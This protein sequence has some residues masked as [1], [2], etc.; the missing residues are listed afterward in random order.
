[1]KY[2]CFS[3]ARLML[4]T[5]LAMLSLS[6]W[7]A[8]QPSPSYWWNESVKL[9]LKPGPRARALPLISVEGNHF[10]KAGG[11]PILFRGVSVADPDKLVSQGHWNKE[12]FAA[13]KG[14]G[15]NIVRIPVHPVS[16]RIHGEQGSIALLDQAVDWCT[17]LGLYVII[18]WHS[19]GNLKSGQYHD[20]MYATTQ[21]E[22]F[23]FWRIIAQHFSGNNTVAFYELFN[24]P[25]HY[26]G[27][28]GNMSWS[29]WRQLNEEMI[30]IIRYSDHETIPLV[31]GFDWAY[32]LGN[33]R[34]EPVNAPGIGYV[35]H[36]YAFKRGQPWEPR[37]EEDFAFAAKQY[38]VLATEIGFDLKS[39]D[40]VDDQHY[41]NRVTRF[42]E[43][44]GI[45]WVAWAF[46]PDWGPSLLKSFDGF[47]LTSTGEFFKAALQ[48]PATPQ[49][50]SSGHPDEECS[51]NYKY[52]VIYRAAPATYTASLVDA[53]SGK[54]LTGTSNANNAPTGALPAVSALN[55]QQWMIEP[56]ENLGYVRLKN[57]GFGTYLNVASDA[58]GAEVVTYTLNAG[59]GSEEWIIEPI[60]GNNEIRLKNVW[61]GKYLTITD[62]DN[63]ATIHLQS[64][65]GDDSGQRWLI[66]QSKSP[67]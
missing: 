30:S 11:G 65:T 35:T 37:W 44:H 45:G 6:A 21:Q 25:T 59:W 26:G 48:R 7:A 28:L 61:T 23:A 17:D 31:A 41:G 67:Q 64:L 8:P 19:I 18:D 24:E 50:S 38:P 43:S 49:C 34:Y 15:A 20:S 47:K 36:P 58:E 29:E 5:V 66:K 12:L 39:G 40:V 56:V 32:D 54:L 57:V 4:L 10:V 42:L 62:A 52:E 3:T 13:V 63:T 53:L 2:V 1:M 51:D 16:W 22:T 14:M 60:A 46:D 27:M 55:N 33:L 9:P